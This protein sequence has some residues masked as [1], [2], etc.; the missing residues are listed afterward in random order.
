MDE[1][2]NGTIYAPRTFGEVVLGVAFERS[3][4]K[5][6]Q[7]VHNVPFHLGEKV[8][9]QIPEISCEVFKRT[10]PIS[11]RCTLF[12]LA[13]VSALPTFPRMKRA[14]FRILRTPSAA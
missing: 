13:R 14:V 9:R 5:N 8:S 6:T 1:Y 11:D 12:I 10:R 3:L 7:L 4:L 2:I